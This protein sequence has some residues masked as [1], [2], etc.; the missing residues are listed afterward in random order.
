MTLGMKITMGFGIIITIMLILGGIGIVNMNNAG[1]NSYNLANKYAPEVDVATRVER[2][3]MKMMYELRGYNFTEDD[4]FLKA[5]LEHLESAKK[6]I[7]DT[8]ALSAKYPELAQLKESAGKIETAVLEYEKLVSA[9]DKTVK[10][11]GVIRN[12]MDSN[13]REFITSVN[14]LLKSQN[15]AMDK[16]IDAGAAAKDLQERHEK[17]TLVNDIIDLGNAIRLANFRAQAMRDM[18]VVKEQMGIF[19]SMEEKIID[20]LK[21]T[22]LDKDIREIEEVR[23]AK[24]GYKAAIEKMLVANQDL[25]KINDGRVKYGDDAL[26]EGELVSRAGVQQ[27][28]DLSND[29]NSQLTSAATTMIIG[30]IAALIIGIL[31]AIFIIRSITKPTIEAVKM[32]ADANSQVLSASDQIAESS[33]S[34]AEGATEQASSVEEVSATVE[35]ATAINNQN[36]ENGREANSLATAANDAAKIGNHKV[37]D[38]MVAMEKITDSSQR[39]AKIIKTIDEIAFQ[40]NLL[41]LNAAVEAARAGEHG[42][43]FAVVADEVKNLAQRSAD[44]AKETATIIEEA[45]EEIKNGNQI[46][47]DTN[48][49]FGE[50]LEKAK[51]TSDLIGEISVSVKEQADGMNQISTAMGQIDQVTQQ[52]AANSEE[53]AAA[54]EQLNAQA[55]SMMQSVEIIGRIVGI[56]I[57]SAHGQSKSTKKKSTPPKKIEHR[58]MTNTKSSPKKDTKKQSPKSKNDDEIF[59][60]DEDDLK[61]F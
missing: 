25:S 50:I 51:K 59:P 21:I 30:L 54:A 32:I 47:K 37:Q 29:A 38:L 9:T 26:K 4:T 1:D 41:A 6:D 3:I 7:A 52:N 42:L 48:E 12:E 33:Q 18:N 22:R 5:G 19:N 40:T 44:A 34:L 20:T 36:A 60:L 35:E 53:A 57:D 8:K 14:A 58:P 27:T 49:S 43:G 23:K 61:E 31:A 55:V 45:I 16:E 46:A 10:A 13:A 11:M 56:Q 24:N 15:E 28:V 39:I 17:I 2:S